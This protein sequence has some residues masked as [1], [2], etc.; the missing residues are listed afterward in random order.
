[1]RRGVTNIVHTHSLTQT[2]TLGSKE[3]KNRDVFFLEEI[4]RF[5]RKREL[6]R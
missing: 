3:E 4:L 6:S 1:M 5:G 2:H